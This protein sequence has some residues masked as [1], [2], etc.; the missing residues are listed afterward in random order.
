MNVVLLIIDALRYDHVSGENTPNLIKLAEKGAF[1][2]NDYSC[3]SSTVVSMPCVLCGQKTY[4]PEK[5]IATLLSQAGLHT[6]MI[7]SNPILHR[8]YPG[9]KETIDLKSKQLRMDKRF[10]KLIRK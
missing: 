10:K 1:F 8:F 2:T 4:N 5:N 6:T 3:N 9:F 7:H